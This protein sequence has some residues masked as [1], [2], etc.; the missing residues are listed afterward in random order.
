M[1]IISG[2]KSGKGVYIYEKG[3]KKKPE[4]DEARVILEKYKLNPKQELVSLFIFFSN[5]SN[6]CSILLCLVYLY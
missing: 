2:R 4:N 1:I 6:L 3:N 5:N